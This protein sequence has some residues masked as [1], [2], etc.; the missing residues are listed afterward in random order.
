MLW[1]WPGKNKKKKNEKTPNT[2]EEVED[3]FLKFPL[4]K[5]KYCYMKT[6]KKEKIFIWQFASI[7]I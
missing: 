5:N 6:I 1:M 2:S 4:Q 7:S 3:P